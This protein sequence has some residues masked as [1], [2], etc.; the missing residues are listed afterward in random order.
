MLKMDSHIHSEYS[1]DSSSKIDDILK[2]ANSRNIDIIAISDHNT[3]DGTS[4]VLRKTRNTCHSIYRNFF[5]TR[6]YPWFWV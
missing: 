5:N 2:V 4:E 1:D 3:V 6:S